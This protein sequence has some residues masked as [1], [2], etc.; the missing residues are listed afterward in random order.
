MPGHLVQK[1]WAGTSPVNHTRTHSLKR[2]CVRSPKCDCRGRVTA[3]GRLSACS[4]CSKSPIVPLFKAMYGS[5]LYYFTLQIISLPD[6]S[7]AE[8]IFPK[9]PMT[10]L[11]FQLLAV[12]LCSHLPSFEQSG[13]IHLSIPLSIL[14]VIITSHPQSS[15]PPVP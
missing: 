15:C 12:P 11:C 1:T 3:P 6:N 4:P 9:N 13:P 2:A 7:K 5:C 8:D 10:H 14:N